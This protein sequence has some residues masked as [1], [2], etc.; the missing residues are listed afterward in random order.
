MLNSAQFPPT[1]TS[2]LPPAPPSHHPQFTQLAEMLI[3]QCD[4]AY[5][6][7][8][9]P[10]QEQK[11]WATFPRL[12]AYMFSSL[13]V[14]CTLSR[15]DCVVLITMHVCVFNCM[16]SFVVIYITQVCLFMTLQANFRILSQHFT[17]FSSQYFSPQNF[18]L[19]SM[20]NRH[21]V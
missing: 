8:W 19:S 13:D 20:R 18:L 21:M 7:H 17:I 16:A 9:T 3:C 1:V 11:R 2:L 5:N 4:S 12:H 10:N 6:I 15:T 14:G